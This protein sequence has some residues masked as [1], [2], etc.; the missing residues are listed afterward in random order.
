MDNSTTI[1]VNIYASH[2]LIFHS[3]NSNKF[4]YIINKLNK[5]R[6]DNPGDIYIVTDMDFVLLGQ[7]G[8]RRGSERRCR[9]HQN[10]QVRLSRQEFFSLDTNLEFQGCAL[11]FTTSDEFFPVSL[12]VVHAGKWTSDLSLRS[13]GKR[14]SLSYSFLPLGQRRLLIRPCHEVSS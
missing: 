11:H 12:F 9:L 4:I 3:F 7:A 13:S 2:H 5:L 8:D 10:V 6:G 1:N 14:S